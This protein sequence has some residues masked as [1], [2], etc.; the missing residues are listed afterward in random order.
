MSLTSTC[1]HCGRRFAHA[2]GDDGSD[3][4]GS[5]G[6]SSRCHVC[7][8][9][10][11]EVKLDPPLSQLHEAKHAASIA[12]TRSPFARR[13]YITHDLKPGETSEPCR[14]CGQRALSRKRDYLIT[15]ETDDPAPF[16]ECLAC[17][18]REQ[19]IYTAGSTNDELR[20]LTRALQEELARAEPVSQLKAA[21]DRVE[22]K[23]TAADH[24]ARLVARSVALNA[25]LQGWG[26]RAMLT[27]QA[28]DVYE[29]SQRAA[30][31][32][33]HRR[34]DELDTCA[35]DLSGFLHVADQ[36][37]SGEVPEL[38][39]ADRFAPEESAA[40]SAQLRQQA[41]RR[42]EKLEE[43]SRQRMRSLAAERVSPHFQLG[44]AV[45]RKGDPHKQGVGVVECVY[46]DLASA[47]DAFAVPSDWYALQEVP[48]TTPE[49]SPWYAV[50]LVSG[51][52][53]VGEND[54]EAAALPQEWERG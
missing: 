15:E 45:V 21:L 5:L 34:L 32:D 54:L 46:Y 1:T 9:R 47:V 27:Q 53:L 26:L 23:L 19:S 11:G 37:V 33:I 16:W 17:E 43:E 39:E 31:A 38:Q 50:R 3:V 42:E 14:K 4:G 40:V 49:S 13:L 10:P 29:P 30:L 44:A 22:H 28:E 7:R 2:L 8:P 25:Q 36:H 12:F 20:R 35:G 18:P 41:A 24:L 51:G 52:V 6:G 48:F